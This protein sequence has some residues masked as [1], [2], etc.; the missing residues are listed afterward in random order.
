MKRVI[1]DEKRAQVFHITVVHLML[2]VIRCRN[3]IQMEITFLSTQV[4]DP[5]E[6]K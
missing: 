3:G 5:E 1:L 6:Y 2:S 4:R